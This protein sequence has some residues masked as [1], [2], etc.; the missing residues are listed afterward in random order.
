[1]Y[2]ILPEIIHEEVLEVMNKRISKKKQSFMT[3]RKYAMLLIEK[4]LKSTAYQSG[5]NQNIKL[6]L[7]LN[8]HIPWT[9]ARYTNTTNC[10]L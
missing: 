3:V 9:T 2:R 6:Y 10:N 5:A 1:M 8:I 4:L 7:T